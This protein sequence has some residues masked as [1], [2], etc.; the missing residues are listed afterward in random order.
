MPVRH[1]PIDFRRE[2]VKILNLN[3]KLCENTLKEKF[4][5]HI[6]CSFEVCADAWNRMV[7]RES[8]PSG[9]QLK[10]LLWTLMF[11]MLY[12][13]QRRSS[14]VLDSDEKT[15]RKWNGIMLRALF[16]IKDTVVS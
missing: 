12:D 2:L 3:T 6:G 16:D 4:R 15:I 13:T 7:E 8:L 1:S 14:V 9:A 10:H 11:L 5:S